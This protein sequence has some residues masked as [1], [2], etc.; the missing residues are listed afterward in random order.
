MKVFKWENQK[1]RFRKISLTKMFLRIKELLALGLS[2]RKIANYLG[3]S[4]RMGL[5]NYINKCNIRESK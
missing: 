5:S 2:V 4:N 3:Y 1:V